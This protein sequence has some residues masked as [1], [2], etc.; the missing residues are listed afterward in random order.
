MKIEITGT[1]D[2]IKKLLNAI[3]GSK[4]QLKILNEIKRNTEPLTGSGEKH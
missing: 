1:T 4:E 2:E 3:S